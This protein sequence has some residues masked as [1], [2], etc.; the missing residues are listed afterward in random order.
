MDLAKGKD[1]LPSSPSTSSSSSSSTADWLG[2]KNLF[3]PLF[4]SY[5]D[6]DSGED[7][8]SRLGMEETGE[9]EEEDY[10]V[11]YGSEEPLLSGVGGDWD[12][13]WNEGWDPLQSYDGEICQSG[14]R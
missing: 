9:E 11:D 14:T 12:N 2:D 5:T 4:W 13:H 1:W 6:A 3:W 7:S 8:S 10:S